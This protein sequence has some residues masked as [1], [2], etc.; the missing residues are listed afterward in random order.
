MDGWLSVPRRGKF[1]AILTSDV[2][3]GRYVLPLAKMVVDAFQNEKRLW[4]KE[5]VNAV[6]D[7]S[8]QPVDTPSD[9]LTIVHRY[10]LVYEVLR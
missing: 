10:V 3:V 2:R 8:N 1:V 5:I 4:L 6:P 7:T 9:D